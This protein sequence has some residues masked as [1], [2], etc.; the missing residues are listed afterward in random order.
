MHLAACG[1]GLRAALTHRRPK[2]K[3]PG[4]MFD[5]RD[6]CW[7]VRKSYCCSCDHP[8]KPSPERNRTAHALC[9]VEC[10]VLCC[11]CV[12]PPG[13]PLKQSVYTTRNRIEAHQPFFVNEGLSLYNERQH[14]TTPQNTPQRNA[15][16][17]CVLQV[18]I[19]IAAG[20]SEADAQSMSDA[21]G[22]QGSLA[23]QVCRLWTF[24]L[25]LLLFRAAYTTRIDSHQHTAYI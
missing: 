1:P 15:T 4:S 16:H 19:N 2:D 3:L 10:A 8:V 13:G 20:M 6:S 23:V 11:L 14:N 9:C 12:T 18:A 7:L 22:F 17:A 21:L 25:L 5:V 24:L